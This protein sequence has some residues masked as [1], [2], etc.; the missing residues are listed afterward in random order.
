MSDFNDI[1]KRVLNQ[2]LG[3]FGLE[4]VTIKEGFD[5]EGQPAL[6]VDAHLKPGS[7][8]V[9]GKAANKAHA[10]LDEALLNAGETRFPYFNIRHHAEDPDRTP[11]KPIRRAS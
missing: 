4:K 8:I 6:F 5:H 7:K 10:A 3:R 2:E 1:A 9:G 11:S